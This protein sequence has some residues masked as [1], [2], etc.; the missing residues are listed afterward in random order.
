MAGIGNFILLFVNFALL[1]ATNPNCTYNT[2][3]LLSC[4]WISKNQ[5]IANKCYISVSSLR[6]VSGSCLLPSGNNPRR[7]KI[8]LNRP[9]AFTVGS[10]VN[11]SVSCSTKE[12]G[13]KSV[14][15]IVY[16]PYENLR[17][18]PPMSLEITPAKEGMWNLSWSCH[19]SSYVTNLREYEVNYKPK[20]SPQKVAMTIPVRQDELFVPLRDLVPDT[21]YEAKV[22]VKN[23]RG[24]WSEWSQPYQWTTHSRETTGSRFPVQEVVIP[25]V[26]LVIIFMCITLII[27]RTQDRVKKIFW[28]G[29]PDPSQ[30][31]DPL[32]SKYGGNFQKWL[33]SPFSL[34]S[35]TLD[36]PPLDIS[37]VDF[38][39]NKEE[40]FNP[41]LPT[42][43]QEAK[44]DGS[45]NSFSSFNNKEYF[46][47]QY[48]AIKE[49][50]SS[51]CYF[52]YDNLEQ[53]GFPAMLQSIPFP[54]PTALEETPLFQGDH[55]S[56]SSSTG[57]GFHNRSF[58]EEH[59]PSVLQICPPEQQ[60]IREQEQNLEPHKAPSNQVTEIPDDKQVIN[61]YEDKKEP[62][63]GEN[64]RP[65]INQHSAINSQNRD[66]AA[67]YISLK[68]IYNRWA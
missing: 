27:S 20:S 47:F 14:E 13:N 43:L 7:C 5:F 45:E 54:S 38:K 62:L 18:D 50:G 23:K 40:P 9:E 26:G 32:I 1:E 67:G 15:S 56:L 35:F 21:I 16:F 49:Q 36:V 61:I 48:P 10:Q 65:E 64:I 28:V 22:R 17:L 57:L 12:V 53:R 25:C 4:S 59:S 55:L 58:E 31:F 46:F 39:C 52:T 29:V 3:N 30:F 37:P 11:I 51:N 41:I 63:N 33:S 2:W 34:S 66:V 60:D 8:H 44:T 42:A 24:I 19:H 6:R 68:E